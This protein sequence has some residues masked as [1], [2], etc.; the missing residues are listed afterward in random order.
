VGR[1]GV[2]RTSGQCSERERGQGEG[3][4]PG[5]VILGAIESSRFHC[6]IWKM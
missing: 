6:G 3:K 1:L 2:T 4:K 5:H